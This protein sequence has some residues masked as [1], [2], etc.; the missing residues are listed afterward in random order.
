MGA[1]ISPIFE[2]VEQLISHPRQL[3]GDEE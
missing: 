2:P 1:A 3:V